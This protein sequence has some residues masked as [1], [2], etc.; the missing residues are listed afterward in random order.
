MTSEW[1]PPPGRE[2]GFYDIRLN[3]S[4][5][6]ISTTNKKSHAPQPLG[7]TPKVLLKIY[8]HHFFPVFCFSHFMFEKKERFFLDL[9]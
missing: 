9:K 1:I 5:F 4:P 7:K 3:A 8:V 6:N 2:A